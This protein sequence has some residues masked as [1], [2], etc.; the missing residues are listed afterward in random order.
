MTRT[1]HAASEVDHVVRG[2]DANAVPCQT[3]R[4]V[5]S[6]VHVW[7]QMPAVSVPRDRAWLWYWAAVAP[8]NYDLG[9]RD[10][11]GLYLVRD[12]LEI[13]PAVLTAATAFVLTAT[14]RASRVPAARPASRP[15]GSH[16]R[17]PEPWPCGVCSC[18]AA[19]SRARS[20]G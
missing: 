11:L 2:A 9:G 3:A 5:A 1:C 10:G 14:Y 6:I 15:R 17:P 19:A 13:Q 7:Q 16:S 4:V 8:G 18:P 20:T 12:V